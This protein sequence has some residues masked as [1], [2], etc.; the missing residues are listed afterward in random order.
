MDYPSDLHGPIS[1]NTTNIASAKSQETSNHWMQWQEYDIKSSKTIDQAWSVKMYGLLTM[2]QDSSIL[3]AHGAGHI[4]RLVIYLLSFLLVCGPQLCVS[5]QKRKERYPA[6]LV[7]N[8]H[9]TFNCYLPLPLWGRSCIRPCWAFQQLQESW[10]TFGKRTATCDA[11]TNRGRCT[12]GE[13][14]LV[15]N[16]IH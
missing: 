8:P 4:K 10:N 16:F 3:P 9:R 14:S 5:P 7:N 15:K 12:W 2:G 13:K 1:T 6:I 11:Q